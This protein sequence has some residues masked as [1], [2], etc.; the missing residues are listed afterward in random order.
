MK[1]L[2]KILATILLMTLAVVVV[3]G[4]RPIEI[5][6]NILPPYPLDIDEYIDNYE[7]YMVTI[8]NHSFVDQEIYMHAELVGDNGVGVDV[9]DNYRPNAPLLIGA[10]EII[11]ITGAE[12][13]DLNESMTTAD[14]NTVGFTQIQLALG[15]LPEGNYEMCIS[16]FDWDTAF[17]MTVGCSFG[18][19]TNFGGLPII[20]TPFEDEEIPIVPMPSFPITWESSGW[21]PM[22]SMG[23]E[24]EIK[25]VDITAHGDTD[26]EDLFTDNGVAVILDEMVMTNQYFYGADGSDPPLEEGHQYGIRIKAIDP[27][28]NIDFENQGF[29]E[30]R[31]FWYGTNPTDPFEDL[32]DVDLDLPDDCASRCDVALPDNLDLATNPASFGSLTIGYFELENIVQ[33]QPAANGRWNAKAD[34]RLPFLNDLR[35]EVS[36]DTFT[37][38]TQGQLISGVV[39]GM[40]EAQVILDAPFFDRFKFI[41]D[42]LEQAQDLASNTSFTSTISDSISALVGNYL[43]DTRMITGLIGANSV[44]LPIGFS[45]SIGGNE[46]TLGITDLKITPQAAK[47]KIVAGASL[48]M[49]PGDNWLLFVGEEVCFHPQGFGGDYTLALGQD[50]VFQKTELDENGVVQTDNSFSLAFKGDDALNPGTTQIGTRCELRMSC[51]GFEGIDLVGEVKFPR[52][53]IVPELPDGS[54]GPDKVRGTFAFTLDRIPADTIPSNNGSNWLIAMDIERFQLKGLKNWTFE[55]D[56]AF[57][58]MS[59]ISNPDGINFHPSYHSRDES[60]EGVYI[61]SGYVSP[62]GELCSDSRTQIEFTDVIIDPK[63]WMDVKL[64]NIL[65]INQGGIDGWRFAI[66]SMGLEITNNN[67]NEAYMDGR[68]HMPLLDDTTYLLYTA[69]IT[70]PGAFLNNTDDFY[71]FNFTVVTTDTVTLPVF[72]ADAHILNDSY[73]EINLGVS[74]GTDTYID[75]YIHSV[76]SINTDRHYPSSLPEIPASI[77]L[78]ELDITLAYHSEDGFD[79]DFTNISFASPQKMLAGFPVSISGFELDAAGDNLN[80]GF[81]VEVSIGEEEEDMGVGAHFVI[82]SNMVM[83]DVTGLMDGAAP[84]WQSAQQVTGNVAGLAKKFKIEG[85]QFDSLYFDVVISGAWLQGYAGFYNDPLPD[86][87]GRDKGVRGMMDVVLPM[88][89]GG[90]LE[91][92]F[93]TYGTPPTAGGVVTYSADY[94]PYWRVDA[95]VVLP[96]PIPLGTL[97]LGIGGFGGGIFKNM[98]KVGAPTFID[99]EIVGTSS[100]EYDQSTYGAFGFEVAVTFAM[101]N[102]PDAFNADLR[103]NATFQNGGLDQI[104]ISGDG[105]FMTPITERDEAKIQAGFDILINLNNPEL[106]NKGEP[107]PGTESFSM[108]GELYVV[109]DYVARANG[110]SGAEIFSLLGNMEGAPRENTFVQAYFHA[111]NESW[112]FK[113]G[114]PEFNYEDHHDPRGSAHLNIPRVLSLD[115]KTYLMLGND[116]PTQL[117]PLPPDI[118]RILNNPSGDAA[119][120]SATAAQQ[121]IDPNG[122]ETGN[123]FAYG[124]YSEINADIDAFLLYATLNVYYGFDM[125]LTQRS[126]PCGNTGELPG[127][128]GWYAQGQIY[129]GLEGGLGLKIKVFGKERK[130]HVVNLAAALALQG[131]GPKPFYLVGRA[132]VYYEVMGGALSG[133]GS[134]TVKV[135]ESC[136]PAIGDPFAGINF[137]ETINPAQGDQDVFIGKTMMVKLGMPV[138]QEFVIPDPIVDND[139]VITGTRY[140]RYLPQLS[141]ELLRPNNSVQQ[142]NAS[143]ANDYKHEQL[144]MTP[145]IAMNPYQGYRLKLKVTAIDYQVD[146]SGNTNLSVN[147]SE[148]SQD[149]IISFNT[150]PRPP[151]LYP[152]VQFTRPL[153]MERFFLQDDDFKGSI[154]LSS[155]VSRSFY[156]PETNGFADRTYLARFTNLDNGES[157]EA[158][159]N[160]SENAPNTSNHVRYLDFYLPQLDNDAIYSMQIIRTGEITVLANIG[161]LQGNGKKSRTIASFSSGNVASTTLKLNNEAIVPPGETSG[162]GELLL[163]HTYFHTSRYN[164]L[165]AKMEA[166]NRSVVY[167]T[168]G[169]AHLGSRVHIKYTGGERFEKRSF[170]K[171]RPN[172]PNLQNLR[173]DERIKVYDPFRKPYHNNASNKLWDFQNRY[174]NEIKNN[175][176]DWDWPDDLKIDWSADIDYYLPRGNI[177]GLFA[178]PLTYGEVEYAWGNYLESI[179]LVANNSVNSAGIFLGDIN[180][181][182]IATGL[183][184]SKL[185][186]VYDTH[187]IVE[188]DKYRVKD[189]AN[190]Y[191][192]TRTTNSWSNPTVFGDYLDDFTFW[193]NKLHWISNNYLSMSNTRWQ[194]SYELYVLRNTATQPD[195]FEKVLTGIYHF[196]FNTPN[197]P[198][199]VQWAND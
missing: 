149:T 92:Q 71:S 178:S 167:K 4:Q 15:L 172:N 147:G 151:D 184:S 48:A 76:V 85:V 136:S 3:Y 104:G 105:Y 84:N 34:L 189:W 89:L 29:S 45:Q 112:F 10:K 26:L 164:Q 134:F 80:L 169:G 150:G 114:L 109:L 27:M 70:N 82:E 94:F 155:A 9:N 198:P 20:V 162:N 106:N 78:P 50:L 153:E 196:N 61:K 168:G 13:R 65:N 131:G 194:G 41:S 101:I 72:I 38:N 6:V 174:N 122:L 166:F 176:L 145:D 86:G 56:E 152:F 185:E 173:Y 113:M 140:L 177:T 24:Y 58:D 133:Q 191:A 36:L 12:L 108:D 43:M 138:D 49:F 144:H 103:F 17:P 16:A 1:I 199:P 35:V 179:G 107:I 165:Y 127:I 130:F 125:N 99:A 90:R 116:V 98:R 132:S 117:P 126:Q 111:S 40:D 68:M 42:G 175:F 88:G 69:A 23:F 159:L 11:T 183:P 64:R 137:F 192:S 7:S 55:I 81:D 154:T 22:M 39:K 115:L 28:G 19:Q 119:G 46:M 66:D 18:F 74:E 97:P 182:D 121:S 190:N 30:I 63:V 160:V 118:L 102:K 161:E 129:A 180:V 95:T 47:V 124:V 60:F 14:I 75:T 37:V 139:G 148:W 142:V 120:T 21:D 32:D 128:N 5:Q 187:Y 62:P 157:V 123:G 181:I 51:D 73:F 53:A 195:S 93:G 110:N 156:F 57:L 31:T 83:A 193:N 33:V 143:W 54:I 186:I 52:N 96:E 170:R 77:S 25:I 87:E 67:L 188:R 100:Y 163:Y 44:G 197:W 59:A 146:P 135:G 2:S 79:D 141:Y 91:A 158:D 171:F 8:I